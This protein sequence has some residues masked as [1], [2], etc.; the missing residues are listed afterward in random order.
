MSMNPAGAKPKLD[1]GLLRTLHVVEA[2]A[3]WSRIGSFVLL[4]LL[5]AAA[6]IVVAQEWHWVAALPFCLLAGASLHGISLFTHEAVHGTLS[7]NPLW[8]GVLGAMCAMPVLQNFSAYRV[9]HLR[10]HRHL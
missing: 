7:R 5:G 2:G 4:Y 1:S 10:H 3:H 6:A 9:L 8:N